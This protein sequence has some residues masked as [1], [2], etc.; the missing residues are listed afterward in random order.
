MSDYEKFKEICDEIPR[1][2][3][4]G[5]VHDDSDFIKW[6]TKSERFLR[7]HFGEGSEELRLFR[8]R[9]FFP[10]VI[11]HV[12]THEHYVME[13]QKK[14]RQ[15]QAEFQVYLEEMEES[16]E[17]VEILKQAS[18]KEEKD[19]KSV[20]IVHGHNEELKQ[21]VARL[22]E[23]QGL[24]AVILHEQPNQGAT[25]IEKFEK[26]SNVGA[27][28]CLFTSD[29]IGRGKKEEKEMGRAR[30]NVVFEA[31]FFM[32]KL[33]RKHVIIIYEQ[34]VELPSDMQGIAYTENWEFGVLKELKGIGY[35]IDLNKLA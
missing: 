16:E 33:G 31:G 19:Y 24:E 3:N 6:R 20:F 12:E 22:I 26:N 32:G 30:Q 10:L 35:E 11:S 4:A 34:G 28:I 9:K 27:A 14:L 17:S 7:K 21:S 18:S 8:A 23:K 15:V 5:V 13:C 2:I 1:L 29:D 25:I